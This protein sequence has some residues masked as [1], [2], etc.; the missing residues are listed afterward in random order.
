MTCAGLSRQAPAIAFGSRNQLIIRSDLV[1]TRTGDEVTLEEEHE[2]GENEKE[3][4]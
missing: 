4:E 3:E 2:H 1:K